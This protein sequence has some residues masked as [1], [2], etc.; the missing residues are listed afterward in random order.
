MVLPKHG[1]GHGS[2]LENFGS[3]AKK[4]PEGL[5]ATESGPEK[6]SPFLDKTQ[7]NLLDLPGAKA[8]LAGYKPVLKVYNSCLQ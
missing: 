2:T 6:S 7:L 4:R 1:V 3:K 8:I 5:E